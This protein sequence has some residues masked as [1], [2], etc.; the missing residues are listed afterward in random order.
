VVAILALNGVDLAWRSVMGGRA[1]AAAGESR[2]SFGSLAVSGVESLS[3]L[4]AADVSGMAHGL[5]GVVPAD[6]EGVVVEVSLGNDS[7]RKVRIEP[8]EFTL[9]VNGRSSAPAG[10]R[11]H[12]SCSSLARRPRA[13][14]RSSCRGPRPPRPSASTRATGQ[15]RCSISGSSRPDRP[16]ARIPFTRIDWR[17]A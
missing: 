7:A 14:C 3:G 12:Q 10:E 5:P 16:R 8:G 1:A 15:S 4:S 2:T 13:G 17:F 6:Q 9:L 11:S